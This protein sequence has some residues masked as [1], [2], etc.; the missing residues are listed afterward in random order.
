MARMD[1]GRDGGA[2]QTI[3]FGR[4]HAMVNARRMELH[5]FSSTELETMLADDA[6]GAMPI[7]PHERDAIIHEIESRE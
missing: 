2:L 1:T 7:R 3:D 6:S 4:L 5:R